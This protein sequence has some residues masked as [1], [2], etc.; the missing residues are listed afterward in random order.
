[1]KIQEAGSSLIKRTRK[2][3]GHRIVQFSPPRSGSTLAYNLLREIFTFSHIEKTHI[4]LPKHMKHKIVATYRHP[5]DSIASCIQCYNQSPTPEVIQQQITEFEKNG[6]YD[7]LELMDT[8]NCL[9]LRYEDFVND[10]PFLLDSIERFFEI[11]L[12]QE[13]RDILIEKYNV[14]SVS[15]QIQAFDDFSE[16]DDISQFHGNHISKYKGQPNYYKT[17]FTKEQTELLKNHFG[18]YM[19]KLAYE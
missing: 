4:L 2:K 16:Y 1:M 15:S 12:R 8:E 10:L 14:D 3:L 19:K 13:K 6:I 9:L 11:R 17:F 7:I 18:T 5:L